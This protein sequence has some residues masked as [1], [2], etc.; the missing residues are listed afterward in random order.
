MKRPINK[1]IILPVQDK[2]QHQQETEKKST[3]QNTPKRTRSKK[4]YHTNFFII[5]LLL[6]LA[7]VPS[8]LQ[9]FNVTQIK[10]KN[11]LYFDKT[12]EMQVIKDKWTM[13]VFYNMSS[14]WQSIKS[15]DGY[16]TDLHNSCQE[17]ELCSTLISQYEHDLNEIN[18]YNQL[19]LL[20]R[21]QKTTET[22]RTLYLAYL[23]IILPHNTNKIL[24]NCIIMKNTSLNYSKIRHRLL[25]LKIIS[26]TGTK[27][28]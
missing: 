6:L 11:A 12:S 20:T 16:V 23:M 27:I 19:L 5:T 22:W 18:H 24:R 25:K 2:E 13:I 10:N 1:I 9:S 21:H 7:I 4:A 14:Y 28:K 8:S 26:F 17:A 15:L 3:E